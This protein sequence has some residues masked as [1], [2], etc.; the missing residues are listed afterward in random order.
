[1]LAALFTSSVFSFISV[2]STLAVIEVPHPEPQA[3]VEMDLSF[4]S[5]GSTLERREAR[6]PGTT[7]LCNAYCCSVSNAS[8]KAQLN[9][10]HVLGLSSANNGLFDAI[11]GQKS[12]V[13]DFQDTISGGVGQSE[14]SGLVMAM[15]L[16]R[17]HHDLSGQP[18]DGESGKRG[19][20]RTRGRS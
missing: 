5:S 10:L 2:A 7:R 1:M 14:V 8:S 13:V 6:P 3:S 15:S 4:G 11:V 12:L 17:N 16:Q 9:A 18:F 20:L 19:S